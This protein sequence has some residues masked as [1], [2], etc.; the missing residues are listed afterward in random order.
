MGVTLATDVVKDE[1]GD[2]SKIKCFNCNKIGHYR[3]DCPDPK[4]DGGI[5]PPELINTTTT[6]PASDLSA[7]TGVTGKP[8]DDATTKSV[9][10]LNTVVVDRSEFTFLQSSRKSMIPKTWLLLDNQS[11]CGVISNKDMLCDIVDCDPAV[12][13]SQGGADML[14]KKGMLGDI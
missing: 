13:H 2:L 10:N 14:N 3:S 9:T 8:A 11:T 12:M 6:V 1:K 7:V 4:K 5:K